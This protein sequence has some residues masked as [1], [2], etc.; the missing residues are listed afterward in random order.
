MTGLVRVSRAVVL[1]GTVAVMAASSAAA[2]GQSQKGSSKQVV[3]Y[4][5]E[6]G[7]Y[8]RDYR[9]KDVKTSG[10]AARL[11]VLNYAFGNVRPVNPD[12]TG[13]VVCQLADEWA[14]YQKP[15]TADE[16]VNGEAVTWP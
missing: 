8:G 15:W 3:G 12:G 5:T 4:F 9:V 6:W 1:L 2:T 16:S 10:S 14:D 7:I 13:P 11:D